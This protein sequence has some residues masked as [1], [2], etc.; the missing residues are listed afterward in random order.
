MKHFTKWINRTFNHDSRKKMTLV[1]GAQYEPQTFGQPVERNQTSLIS[2]RDAEKY[3]RPSSLPIKNTLIKNFQFFD[4][5][6][7]KNYKEIIL[8]ASLSRTPDETVLNYFSILREAENL[9]P[10]QLGGCGTVGMA[11]LPY[12]IAYNFF[13]KDYQKR[14]S[15]NKYLQSFAGIGHINLVKKNRLPD[16][17]G[18]V[19][20]FV[21]LE[22]IE[23]SSKGVTYFAY[24]YGY[25]QLKKVQ[26]MYKIDQMKLYGE[27]F[28]CAAYHLWQH[29]AEAVVGIMYGEWCKLIKKQLPTKQDGYVKTIDYFGTD[30]A[31]YRFIF[32]QLTND[33]DVLISQYKKDS[34]GNWK[35]IRIDPYKCVKN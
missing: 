18:I 30:G 15:Y 16:E 3:F 23:G 2:T 35:S 7:D 8:P 5:Y 27:D 34:E 32:Y 14:V 25:V 17:N 11:R 21:E 4:P 10:N 12:P 24:Y 29:D 28:L 13:T 6:Y 20:Y 31:Y 22:S 19:P 26:N 1:M 33:T 9:T